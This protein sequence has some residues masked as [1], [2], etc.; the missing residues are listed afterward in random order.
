MNDSPVGRV[1]RRSAVAALAAVAVVL[2]ALSASSLA[3]PDARPDKHA[4]ARSASASPTTP[5]PTRTPAPT[6]TPTPT[7]EPTPA[8]APEASPSPAAPAAPA[9]LGDPVTGVATYYTAAGSGGACMPLT[10]PANGYTA[11]AGPA[12]FDDGR[13]CGSWVEVTGA[14]GT[15][16][17]KIDNLCPECE[18]GHLDLSAEAFAAVDDPVK[19]VVPIVSRVVRNPP[20]TGG[21]DVKVKD[22]SSQ[23]WLGLHLDNVGNAV[24]LVEVADGDGAFRPLTRQFW[25]WT[26][27]SSPGA[28]PYRVRV[29]DVHGQ[30]AVA[31][32]ITLTPGVL[33]STAARLY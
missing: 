26:L 28:G 33:Q 30:S 10:F 12:L 17:V 19:G 6:S 5:T 13:A 23:W 32:G 8:A 18:P 15:V 20:V 25:G 31:D 27:E 1:V 16:L 14:R 2:G 29:T 21:L 11:A 7:P 3:A 24:A 22:G 4:A 9:T